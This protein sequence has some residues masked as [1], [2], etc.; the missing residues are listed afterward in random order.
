MSQ[1][2]GEDVVILRKGNVTAPH[3]RA[4]GGFVVEILRAERISL[5]RWIDWDSDFP[6]FVVTGITCHYSICKIP[7][8][9]P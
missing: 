7:V 4:G 1:L 2:V 6:N 5:P 3:D 9:E 8:K